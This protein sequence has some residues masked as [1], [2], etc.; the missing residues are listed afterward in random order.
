[1]VDCVIQRAVAAPV[2]RG[3]RQARQRLDR[4]IRAQH[5]IGQLEQLITA[6]GQAGTEVHA[7]PRQHGQGLD[8]GG[9]LKQAVHHGLRGYQVS[10]GENT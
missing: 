9:M 4:P 10:F 3:Q 6:N 5:R 8:I 7:E 1:M 2:L